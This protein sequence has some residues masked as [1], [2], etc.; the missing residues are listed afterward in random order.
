[1]L[2]DVHDNLQKQSGKGNARA[3][4]KVRKYRNE[5]NDRED[6]GSN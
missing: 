4:A 2:C 6:N 1:M 3:V 5:G